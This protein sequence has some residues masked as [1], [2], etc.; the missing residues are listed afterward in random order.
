MKTVKL[1][2]GWDL[3]VMIKRLFNITIRE[4]AKMRLWIMFV[5]IADCMQKPI[6]L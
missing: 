4:L 3:R 2:N 1:L 6:L 5:V